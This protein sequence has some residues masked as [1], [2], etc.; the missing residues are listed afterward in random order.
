VLKK[1]K[2]EG[3]GYV[4]LKRTDEICLLYND[5][6]D[7]YIITK[8]SQAH[9]CDVSDVLLQIII[10]NDHFQIQHNEPM[11]H[12]L[13]HQPS[14]LVQISELPYYKA[15]GQI[16]FPYDVMKVKLLWSGCIGTNVIAHY[17]ENLRAAIR[18]LQ[19]SQ[20]TVMADIKG[21]SRRNE[22]TKT[23]M[24]SIRFELEETIKHRMENVLSSV[25]TNGHKVSA[26][27]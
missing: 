7:D 10:L 19:A 6:K 5:A 13:L 25:D 24:N 11:L 2:P 15:E 23:A 4:I 12:T 22:K 16:Y 20:Q 26:G 17:M 8:Y 9:G 18:E 14:P 3:G 21:R 27:K 1:K